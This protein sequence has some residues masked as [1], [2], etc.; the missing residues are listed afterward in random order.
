MK[1]VKI[2]SILVLSLLSQIA[3]GQK[4]DF[5]NSREPIGMVQFLPGN[6]YL[7]SRITS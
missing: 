7:V 4:V 6:K 5:G 1:P 3:V 2:I